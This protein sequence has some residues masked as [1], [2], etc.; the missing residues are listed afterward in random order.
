MNSTVNDGSST[1][2]SHTFHSP[3]PSVRR[4]TYRPLHS[5]TVPVSTALSCEPSYPYLNNTDDSNEATFMTHVT[6]HPA[7]LNCIL[8]EQRKEEYEP[9][10]GPELKTF[11]RRLPSAGTRLRFNDNLTWYTER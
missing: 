5:Y 7:S 10:V 6:T 4:P 11:R 3:V 1:T 8:N 9:G 2:Q